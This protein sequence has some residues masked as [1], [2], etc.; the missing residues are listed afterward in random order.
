MTLA[1][2]EALCKGYM[3]VRSRKRMKAG[4]R[5]DIIHLAP[6]FRS[7]FDNNTSQDGVMEQ[8]VKNNI[9]SS[10]SA[11]VYVPPPAL[12]HSSKPRDSE[13]L[14]HSSPLFDLSDTVT[15]PNAE[16]AGFQARSLSYLVAYRKLTCII[17]A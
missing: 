11:R 16:T 1:Q 6:S 15:M 17:A 5:Y 8:P 9:T 10:A 4:K 3:V 13:A 2:A 14:P 12:L 7:R